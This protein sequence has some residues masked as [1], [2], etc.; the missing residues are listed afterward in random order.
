MND[1]TQ[2]VTVHWSEQVWKRNTIEVRKDEKEEEI[3]RKAMHYLGAIT[4]DKDIM[5]ETVNVDKE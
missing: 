4:I 1:E 3:I 5:W 2:T